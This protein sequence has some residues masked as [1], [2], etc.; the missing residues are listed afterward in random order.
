MKRSVL[1]LMLLVFAGSSWGQSQSPNFGNNFRGA[2]T[3]FIGGSSAFPGGVTAGT[4]SFL[5]GDVTN[6]FRFNRNGFSGLFVLMTQDTPFAPFGRAAERS[7]NGFYD[8]LLP[9]YMALDGPAMRLAAMG[10]PL[11]ESL[12]GAV[13]TFSAVTVG[14]LNGGGFDSAGSGARS[15]GSGRPTLPGLE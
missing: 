4:V 9:T 3:T 14:S 8:F 11:T 6:G 2:V 1:A 15:S 13:E 12:S 5:A 10:A 7:F